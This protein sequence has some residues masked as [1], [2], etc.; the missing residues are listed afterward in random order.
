MYIFLIRGELFI[1]VLFSKCQ[2]NIG[3]NAPPPGATAPAAAPGP[4]PEGNEPAK[5]DQ[6]NSHAG[7]KV[8]FIFQCRRILVS[9]NTIFVHYYR[10]LYVHREQYYAL[11]VYIS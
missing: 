8:N 9:S 2:V 7:N 5:P 6:E 11:F 1:Y 3:N 4:G 10:N